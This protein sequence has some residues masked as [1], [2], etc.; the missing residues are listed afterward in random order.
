MEACNIAHT[1]PV[2]EVPENRHTYSHGVSVAA[3]RVLAVQAQNC[4]LG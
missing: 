2:H 3:D 1:R 4:Y